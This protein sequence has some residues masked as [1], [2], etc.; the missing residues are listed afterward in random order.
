MKLRRIAAFLPLLLGGLVLYAGLLL[1]YGLDV[2]TTKM[3]RVVGV[4][5]R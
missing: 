3:N 4:I 2:G 1:R 5:E